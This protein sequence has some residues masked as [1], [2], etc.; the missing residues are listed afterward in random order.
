M[1]GTTLGGKKVADKL[2]AK[3]P[4]FYR[5]IGSKG[6]RN[7]AGTK[8]GFAYS[9]ETAKSAGSKG[10]AVS[11][12]GYKYIR[13]DKDFHYYIEKATGEEARFFIGM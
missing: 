7:G 9:S 4:D 12:R 6:G 13:S 3:D 8:K 10:G 1:P 2:R 5:K 11:K